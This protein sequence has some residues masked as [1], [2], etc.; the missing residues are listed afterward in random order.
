[1]S[2]PIVVA[3]NLS[4]DDTVTPDGAFTAAPGGDALYASLGMCAWGR[5]PVLLTLVGDDYPAAHLERIAAAGVDVSHVRWTDGPTVHY[6]VTYRPDGSRSF[7]WIS[8]E[9]RLLLTSPT[10]SDYGPLMGAIWLHVAAMPIEAQEAAVAA[11]RAAGVPISLDPHEEY[12]VGFE[13]RLAS[14]IEGVA[15][16]PS[17]LEARLL[18]PDLVAVDGLALGFAAAERLD[19]WQ[20]SLVAIKLGALG[21]IV[22]WRGRSVH[23]P[24][25]VV[26]VVDP[27]GAGDAYCGGFVAGWLA[28]A[29]PEVAA[30]CGTIAAKETIGAFGA[31][32]NNRA[33]GAEERFARL[34]EMLVGPGRTGPELGTSSL[35]SA[36]ASIRDQLGI[37]PPA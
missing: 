20:P 21:S 5:T 15:F 30:A 24:A 36:L 18:F 29:S 3:G 7:E 9:D 26:P 11:G 14:L 22:R 32:S 33:R 27:T 1:M 31:F 8:T 28:T 4:L 13:A 34:T 2:L 23:V 19:A 35:A 25:P 12:V 6:R 37:G 16:M 17:E 10:P